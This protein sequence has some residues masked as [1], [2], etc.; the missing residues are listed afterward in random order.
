MQRIVSSPKIGR[1]SSY[2]ITYPQG[3]E[4]ERTLHDRIVYLPWFTGEAPWGPE[5]GL[6][7]GVVLG[8]NGETGDAVTVKVNSPVLETLDRAAYSSLQA[9]NNIMPHS[10]RSSGV[11]KC[12]KSATA[13]ANVNSEGQSSSGT[14]PMLDQ[15][16]RETR[17]ERL[18]IT[19]LLVQQSTKYAHPEM[20][21]RG[22]MLTLDEIPI[23]ARIDPGSN[24]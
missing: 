17:L 7:K 23:G 12:P 19:E 11:K 9:A 18:P 22:P 20:V 10:V 13:G 5:P 16:A 3:S 24:S 15:W 21:D 1:P 14:S 8:I 2:M 6:Y 4:R